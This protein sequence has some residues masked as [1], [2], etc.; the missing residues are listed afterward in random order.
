MARSTEPRSSTAEENLDTTSKT[1]MLTIDAVSTNVGRLIRYGGIVLVC[2]YVYYSVVVLAGKET[3]THFWVQLLA[4]V[5]ISVA[6]AWSFAVTGVGYG[7]SQRRMRRMIVAQKADRIRY[8]EERFY[9]NRR[10]SELTTSGT[11]RPEDE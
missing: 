4:N 5:H 9:P 3:N 8:L 1:T 6:L 10:S 2:R 7:L 11:T